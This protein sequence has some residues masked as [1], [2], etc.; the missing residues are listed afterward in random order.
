MD[1]C[2]VNSNSKNNV[3]FALLTFYRY[4]HLGFNVYRK[5]IVSEKDPFKSLRELERNIKYLISCK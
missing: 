5:V 3:N 1:P 4:V 2:I